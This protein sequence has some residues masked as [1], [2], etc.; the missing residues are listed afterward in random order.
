M[1]PT[2]KFGVSLEKLIMTVRTNTFRI[3]RILE[4]YCVNLKGSNIHNDKKNQT[5]SGNG[6]IDFEEFLQLM[7]TKTNE[8]RE[9]ASREEAE[10]R[11]AF[12]VFDQ[13]GD[14]MKHK[15]LY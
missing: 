14:G 8:P 1:S 15:I 5:F 13:N 12:K 10:L 7:T 4:Q 2:Q 11:E 9:Q 3:I 6:Q